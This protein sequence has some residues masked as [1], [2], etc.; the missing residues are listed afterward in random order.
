MPAD[1][2][3][4]R[5]L[6]NERYRTDDYRHRDE[7]A[8]ILAEAVEW[9]PDGR[10]L[11]VATGAGRNARFLAAHG[12]E[13]DAVDVSEE[14]L[15]IA[16]RKAADSGVDVNWIQADLDTFALPTDTYAVVC[17]VGY[18]D[19]ELLEPLK[20]ALVR[21]G[22]LLYEHH[23]G[24]AEIAD[25]GPRTDR[26]RARSNEILRAC[27][28]LTVLDYRERSKTYDAADG[29]T[30]IDP[31]VSLVARNGLDGEAWYPPVRR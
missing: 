19:V 4:D 5:E 31:R 16:R 15:A 21:G 9:L 28:D 30:E 6:W 1:G 18:Y 23:L 20:E 2:R 14:G 24:P 22:I 13:V 29:T 10:A 12:Y 11:D 27:L 17:V 3:T 8:A 26:F 25:R 7:P